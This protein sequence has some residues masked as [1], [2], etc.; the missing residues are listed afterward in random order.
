MVKNNLRERERERERERNKSKEL[1]L[2]SNQQYFYF[3]REEN[4]LTNN[5]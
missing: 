3:I 1:Y 2:V 5:K 4:E